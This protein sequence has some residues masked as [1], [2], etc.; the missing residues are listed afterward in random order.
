M[1]PRASRTIL[2][3]ERAVSDLRRGYSVILTEEGKCP[4]KVTSGEHEPER[5]R[6]AVR[7]SA[8]PAVRL[9]KLCGLLPQAIVNPLADDD[10]MNL[11]SV[12]AGDIMAYPAALAATL[13]RVSEARVPIP[14]AENTR[15]VAFRPRFGH[16]EHLAVVIGD[17]ASHPAPLVRL[18]SSC[19]TGDIF[20]SLRCDCGSQLH[21]AL[22]RIAGEGAGAVL[23]LSQEGR[24]IGIANKLRAYALQ[25]QGMDTVD[26]NL[27]LGFEADER[28]FAIAAEILRQLGLPRVTLLTNNPLKTEALI[29]LGIEVA[30]REPLVTPPTHQNQSY[31]ETKAAKMG[32][33]YGACDCDSQ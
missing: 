19:V 14:E 1:N 7:D 18:H 31:L 9:L 13:T 3:V 17:P 29:R 10:T 11:L 22:R 21:K 15:L 28:D 8:S 5:A 16:E 30:A 2:Q 26:S 24:G 23:Y 27:A 25:D 12:S 6:S 4:V 33:V 20:S 32:H